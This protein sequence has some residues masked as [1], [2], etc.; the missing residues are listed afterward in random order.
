MSRSW[1]R[2]GLLRAGAVVGVT[3]L[4]GCAASESTPTPTPEPADTADLRPDTIFRHDIERT[5]YWPDRSVPSSVSVDWE[6]P[7]INK[8]DHTAAKSSPLTYRGD[9][10]VPGDVGTVFSFTPAGE[11]NW[12]TALHPSNWG[13]HATPAIADGTLYI[14]G[15]D[16]AVY[17]IDTEDGTILWRTKVSDAIGSSPIFYDGR[18]YIATEFYTPSGGMAILE[19]ETGDP[20]WED[21]RMTD[22]AH[23]ITGLDPEEG[24]FA[25]G[26]NDGALYVWEMAGPTFRGSYE[27]GEAIK[28]PICLHDGRAIFG[29]WSD[30][31]YGVDLETL[32]ADWTYQTDGDVMAGAAVHPPTGVAVIGSAD[33]YVHAIDLES[34]DRR[35]RFETGGYVLGSPTIVG[36]TVLAGSYDSTLYALD[37]Q[38]GTRRWAFTEPPGLV[39]ATPAVADDAVYVTARATDD[40]TGHL[41]RLLGV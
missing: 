21:L 10:I 39:T 40:S 5:G 36:D 18:I 37:V 8:G 20:V 16:G 24:V 1:S 4:A 35:W 12:A 11:L 31:V 2:R 33:D 13:T 15:Y 19:A 30:T 29:S 26:C 7:G 14:S 22:H 6:V 27:T 3:A 41:Y 17:A 34:G 25:A 9:V 32:E 23:S 28:G 38:D